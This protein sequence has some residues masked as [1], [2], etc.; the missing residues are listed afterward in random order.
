VLI[1]SVE[2]PVVGVLAASGG[3]PTSLRFALPDVSGM[4]LHATVP[5]ALVAVA[6]DAELDGAAEELAAAASVV[7]SSPP[8][9]EIT[10]N[11]PTTARTATTVTPTSRLRRRL[12]ASSSRRSSWRCSR[13]WAASRRCLL[14][15]TLL[16]LLRRS[17]G[18]GGWP[19]SSR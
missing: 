1:R 10:K 4:K 19:H 16:G 12:R 13:R 7:P 14:V 17:D 6:A 9:L 18:R 8:R 5:S 11:A 2:V 15:G 3:V